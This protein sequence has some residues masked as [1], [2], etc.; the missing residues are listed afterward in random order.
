MFAALAE[1]DPLL[2][3][4]ITFYV[5]SFSQKCTI[6][7][8]SACNAASSCLGSLEKMNAQLATYP[9]KPGAEAEQDMT[10][11]M[12]LSNFLEEHIEVHAPPATQP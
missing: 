9:H 3:S 8:N 2:L 5:K 7:A 6:L 10:A 4:M 1:P 11:L 12:G